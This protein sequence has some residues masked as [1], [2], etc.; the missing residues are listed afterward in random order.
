MTPDRRTQIEKR[1]ADGADQAAL[2]VR[3]E[4][5]LT[6]MGRSARADMPVLFAGQR[7]GFR[8]AIWRGLSR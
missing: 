2:G 4:P 5:W 7:S 1:L 8:A 3:T 6:I